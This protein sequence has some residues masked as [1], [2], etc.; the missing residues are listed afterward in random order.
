MSPL[1]PQGLTPLGTLEEWVSTYGAEL[2]EDTW[3]RDRHTV[4]W[5]AERAAERFHACS[6]LLPRLTLQKEGA[7]L[8][9]QDPVGDVLQSNEEVLAEVQGWDLPPLGERYRRACHSL[10]TEPDRLLL[11]V[12]ARGEQSPALALGGSLGLRPPRLPPL[13]RALKLQGL[14]QLRL[15]ACGLADVTVP[16]LVAALAALPGLLLLDLS[17]NRLGAQGLRGLLPPPGTAGACQSLQ[18]LDLSLNPLG[19]A[20]CRPLAQLLRGCPALTTLRLRACG[21]TAAFCLPGAE[22]LQSLSLSCN[23]LGPAALER[24]LDAACC[25]SLCRLELGSVTGPA[26]RPLGAALAGFLAQDGCALSHLTLAGNHL[27]DSDVLEVARCLP[28]CPALVSLDL[29]ANPGVGVAGLRALLDAL[30]E[31]GRG[32]RF[33]SLAGC[34]VDGPSDAAT[35]AKITSLIQDLRLCGRRVTQRGDTGDTSTLARHRKLFCKSR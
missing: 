19:D 16:E 32:L 8:A 4:A 27:G 22:R 11:Q 6:G 25:R 28:S 14:R 23:A 1:S 7:L 21:F 34:S 29:S 24:L 9:P 2:D 31:R 5:L 17:G 10:G 3:R 18:E 20:A 13:L 12:T 15:R 35:W 30:G 26:P 33:L